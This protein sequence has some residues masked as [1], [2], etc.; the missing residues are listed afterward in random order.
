[1]RSCCKLLFFFFFLHCKMFLAFVFCRSHTSLITT[2]KTDIGR[3]VCLHWNSFL[4]YFL[5]CSTL[6]RETLKNEH[7]HELFDNRCKVNGN[8]SMQTIG[9]TEEGALMKRSRMR[10]WLDQKKR[11]RWWKEEEIQGQTKKRLRCQGCDCPLAGLFI[12]TT[13]HP[14]EQLATDT[15]QVNIAR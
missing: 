7:K 8:G 14:W 9:V 4:P 5:V 6:F 12:L 2:L 11:G 3:L 15:K 13:V 10:P 1:M